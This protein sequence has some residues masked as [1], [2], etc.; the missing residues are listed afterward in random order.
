M[1]PVSLDC[2]CLI[3]PSLV[4]PMLPVSLD[5]PCLIVLPLVSRGRAIKHGQSR[6]TGSIGY[7]RR[8]AIK[9]GQSRKTGNE[10]KAT[11]YT[12]EG[13]FSCSLAFT[14]FRFM[15]NLLIK[16]ID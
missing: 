7:T 6:E 2:P 13:L 4:Y 15:L 11:F 3:D 1:L 9:H 14:T 16:H 5:C 8:R 10:V 12:L